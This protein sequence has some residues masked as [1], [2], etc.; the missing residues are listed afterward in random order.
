MHTPRR[1]TEEHYEAEAQR[2]PKIRR[3]Q[4]GTYQTPSPISR[5]LSNTINTMRA[6][7]SKEFER[8]YDS[9]SG[10]TSQNPV[11]V[12]KSFTT[13]KSTPAHRLFFSSPQ[14]TQQVTSH[15]SP[16]SSL[17]PFMEGHSLHHSGR[18]EQDTFDRK[19]K[20]EAPNDH[21]STFNSLSKDAHLWNHQST[22]SVSYVTRDFSPTAPENK[23]EFLTD[24]VF[25]NASKNSTH[26]LF[27]MLQ[28]EDRRLDKLQ[29]D[30]D[31]ILIKVNNKTSIENPPAAISSS[32]EED[33]S[34][35]LY[36]PDY[37][38]PISS[39]H[40]SATVY[41]EQPMRPLSPLF[42][43]QPLSPSSSLDTSSP[44]S[45]QEAIPPPPPPPPLPPLQP[46]TKPSSI[47]APSTILKDKSRSIAAATHEQTN[48]QITSP[49]THTTP[50]KE[51]HSSS[52]WMHVL[53]QDIPKAKLRSAQY[54][55]TPEGQQIHNKFWDEIHK[56]KT[57]GIQS[58]CSSFQQ[59][60]SSP[61]TTDINNSPF[62]TPSQPPNNKAYM[63][64]GDSLVKTHTKK[65]V[66]AH[67][68]ALMTELQNEIKT[69][70]RKLIQD[71]EWLFSGTSHTF[72]SATHSNHRLR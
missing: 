36:S 63:T 30:L 64:L 11:S 44:V 70:Q 4:T 71:D 6:K 15:K 60:T 42:S 55:R 19:R 29:K 17:T 33:C 12:D 46:T 65:P 7:G 50:T 58:I 51:S 49:Q 26:S 23:Y 69:K 3:I 40:R 27:E 20:R 62:P 13:V 18:P 56:G 5:F 53:V 48:K 54:I 68:T 61:T 28:S 41:S 72:K 52:K 34:R 2:T 32:T 22:D 39:P 43:S 59:K 1:S 9:F 47:K 16:H 57:K 66:S 25:S 24:S 67:T 45:S 8:L 21:N 14:R 31:S 37:R 35:I 38:Y 10:M